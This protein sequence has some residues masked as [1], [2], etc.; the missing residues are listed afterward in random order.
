MRR[1]FTLLVLVAVAACKRGGSNA[2][3]GAAATA[4][5][6]HT[7]ALPA[8]VK[9][10][11]PKPK[12]LGGKHVVAE[13]CKL[14]TAGSVM[15]SQD[16]SHAIGGI[17][18]AP[19]GSVYLVDHEGKL[20]HYTVQTS[21]C[22]LALDPKFGTGG[23]LA[24]EPKPDDSKE[25]DTVSIDPKGNL[26]VSGGGAKAKLVTPAGQVSTACEDTG[27]FFVDRVNGDTYLRDKRV[28]VAAGGKCEPVS[29]KETWEGWPAKDAHAEVEDAVN[30]LVFLD[31]W[32][33]EKGKMVT[34]MGVHKPDGKKL[35]LVGEEKGDGEICSSAAMQ[36]CA[37]GYCVLD[38]NCRE[39]RAWSTAGGKLVGAFDVNELFGVG[40]SWP[41]GLFVTKGVTWATFSEQGEKDDKADAEA[42]HFGF[43]ARITGLD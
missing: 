38:A 9:L 2:D 10:E 31:G 28:T 32:I 11:A 16:F 15:Q 14:D 22:Q 23:V 18:A 42:P 26:Y 12:D 4:G 5:G 17:V 40:Y 3:A 36:P 41:E 20:R 30:G 19:D 25:Y 37:L 8:S 43:V 21:P 34:K 6:P 39:M 35:E 13:V 1:H 27:R 29:A 33:K 7:F 24:M